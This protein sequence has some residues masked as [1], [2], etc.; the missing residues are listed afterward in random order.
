MPSELSPI[1][2]VSLPRHKLDADAISVCRRLQDAGFDTLLVGGCV[3]D[4]ILGRAPKDFDVGTLATPTEVRRLFRNCRIIG[5]RFRLAHIHF[6]PKIIEVATFRGGD[7]DDD[8]GDSPAST[9]GEADGEASEGD[10]MIVRANNFGTPEQDALSRDFTINA[11]FYDPIAQRV[12]D[13]VNGYPDLRAGRLRTIGDPVQRFEED[14]VRILRCMKFAARLDFEIEAETLDG[15]ARVAPDI[16]RCPVARVTEEIYRIAECRHA[17]VA[18]ELMHA[19][20]VLRTLL[21]ELSD[22]MDRHRSRYLEHLRV[23]DQLGRAHDGLQR[24]FV[25]SLLYLPLA[26]EM[27]EDEG[28]APGTNWGPRVEEWFRPIGVRMHIAVKHRAR[29]RS[30]VTL[31][32][33]MLGPPPRRKPSLGAHDRRA[34]PQALTMLRLYH[35]VYGDATAAYELWRERADGL[36]L[37]WV[38]L[39]E[40][41]ERAST[42]PARRR[43]RRRPR[44]PST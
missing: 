43:R 14:P 24:E 30:L 33:R 19:N 4:I 5:R 3:R 31:L 40:V 15:V 29:L 26:L 20:G 22:Y 28:M 25:L 32:G 41:E 17:A 18:F 44:S 39:A 21:P 1:L 2:P 38:P 27:L 13:H 36:G 16:M 12:I 6:G 42:R 34:L 7:V 11:L 35:R 9:G 23:V 8:A 10:R 37:T